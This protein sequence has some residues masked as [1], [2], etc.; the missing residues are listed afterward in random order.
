[1]VTDLVVVAMLSAPVQ[2]PA[3]EP[4][5]ALQQLAPGVHAAI[6]VRNPPAYAFANSLVVIGTDGVLVVDTQQSPSAARSLI[7]EIARLTDA[8]VRWVVNTHWHGDHV[9][10]NQAYAAA[11]PGVEFIA[12]ESL[13][14]ELGTLAAARRATELVELPASIELRRTWLRTGTGPNGAALLAEDRAAVERSLRLR[15]GYHAELVSIVPTRPTRTFTDRLELDVGGQRV[16]LTHLG[17]AHTTGDVV[18]ALPEHGIVAVGDLLE[19][20]LPYFDDASP[21]GWLR[22]VERIAQMAP[23]VIMPSHGPVSRDATLLDEM[24]TL[25]RLVTETAASDGAHDAWQETEQRWNARYGVSA[26]AFR[27]AME[28][29]LERVRLERAR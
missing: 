4:V 9:N 23:A 11:F 3:T 29:A 28:T 10:G 1:M 19:A 2:A 13:A 20:G 17:P 27:G 22:A 7:A 21:A 15:E 8:P 12:H 18:V 6:V 26:A 25:L 24:R 14:A 5:F 16:V